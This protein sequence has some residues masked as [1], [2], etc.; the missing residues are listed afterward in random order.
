MTYH[1]VFN[2]VLNPLYVQRHIEI[3][4]GIWARDMPENSDFIEDITLTLTMGL[5]D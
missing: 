1:V 2:E 4:L 3:C 5:T